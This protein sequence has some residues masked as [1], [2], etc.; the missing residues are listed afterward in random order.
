MLLFTAFAAQRALPNLA[1]E[2]TVVALA[3]LSRP[4]AGDNLRWAGDPTA[5]AQR[6]ALAA[7]IEEQVYATNR[8]VPNVS[9]IL[10]SV[11]NMYNVS[12][13]AIDNKVTQLLKEVDPHLDQAAPG[14]R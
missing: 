7:R 9:S 8:P 4:G 3:D 14:A 6:Q 10:P 12:K 2:E 13:P 11:V 1:D 5:I